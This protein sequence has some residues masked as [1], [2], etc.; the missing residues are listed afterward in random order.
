MWHAASGPCA[1]CWRAHFP[2][3]SC[4]PIAPCWSARPLFWPSSAA[5]T[6]GSASFRTNWTQSGPTLAVVLRLPGRP[7][8]QAPVLRI[9][10]PSPLPSS[11]YRGLGVRSIAPASHPRD[12][13]DAGLFG[14]FPLGWGRPRPG[15]PGVLFPSVLMWPYPSLADY[16]VIN[17]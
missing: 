13:D 14:A 17:L 7:G 9:N 2:P 16:L 11:S 4:A 1:R 15:L 8:P 5:W 3:T 10:R 12:W 6:S